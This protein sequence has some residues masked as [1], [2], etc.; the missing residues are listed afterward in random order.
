MDVSI[1]S[2][3]LTSEEK[4][5][6]SDQTQCRESLLN[7]HFPKSNFNLI[8][9]EEDMHFKIPIK[10]F[11]HGIKIHATQITWLL[12][13]TDVLTDTLNIIENTLS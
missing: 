5:Y 3:N 6:A 1:H 13:Q 12:C 11:L 4:D 9:T 2:C 7:I 8:Y 10:Y